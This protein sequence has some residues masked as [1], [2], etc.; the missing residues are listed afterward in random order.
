M[1]KIV[2]IT[3]V[4]G[5]IGSAAAKLFS[6]E[7]W[8]VIGI[9]KRAAKTKVLDCFIRADVSLG[10]DSE[11]I[12]SRI[13]QKYGRID[14]LVNNAAIQI[15]KPLI[16]TSI[17][18]WDE[19]MTN[20]VRSVYLSAK[21]AY[22]LMKNIGGAIVNVSSVHAL[23]TSRNMASYAA[24]KGALVSFTRALAIEL[25]PIRIRVNAVLPG[26]VDT[27]MLRQHLSGSQ[28]RR[29]KKRQLFNRITMPQ[30]IS[31]T[32][33]FLA[34]NRRSSCMTGEAVLADGGTM[35]ILGTEA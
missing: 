26:A 23:A 14:A 4:T 11:N 21:N 3:G 24:S 17:E 8:K 12:F 19:V 22:P 31:E 28:L 6:R 30:E 33:M 10:S 7:K 20:N 18:E 29:L 5:G 15:C 13:R 34:D 25:A 9:D 2:V 32:I 1:K 27:V 16:K 35:A